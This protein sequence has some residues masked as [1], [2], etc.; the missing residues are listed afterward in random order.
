[1]GSALKG[2]AALYG[3]LTEDQRGALNGAGINSLIKLAGRSPI[4]WGARTLAGADGVGSD[5][6]YL[7]VR[8]L[9]LLIETSVARGLS[10]TVFEPNGERLWASV[11]DNV[12]R[13]LY[14]LFRQGAFQG[15][16]ARDAFFVRCDRETMTQDDLDNGRLVCMIGFAPLKPA[17]FVILR[18]VAKT[19]D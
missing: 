13:F 5:W 11:R 14:D 10:W 3:S 18:I 9:A 4:V 8:R 16:N 17:E 19:A 6:K 7:P 12:A 15:Q 2:A 1:M